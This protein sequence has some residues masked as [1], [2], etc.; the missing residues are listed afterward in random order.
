ME[1][2]GVECGGRGKVKNSGRKEDL[3]GLYPHER[4]EG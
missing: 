2:V 3:V 1:K 4:E